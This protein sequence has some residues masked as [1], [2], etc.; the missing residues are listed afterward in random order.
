MER[1]DILLPHNN[2]GDATLA[3]LLL[4]LTIGVC[5]AMFLAV[6]FV[7]VGVLWMMGVR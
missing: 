3:L 2:A 4:I 5:L 6:F 7:L 1:Y